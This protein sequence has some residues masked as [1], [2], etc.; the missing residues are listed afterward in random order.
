NVASLPTHD[1]MLAREVPLCSPVALALHIDGDLLIGHQCPGESRDPGRVWRVDRSSR[2]IHRVAGSFD[3]SPE[4]PDGGLA[5]GAS[6]DRP[7]GLATDPS[8]NVYLAEVQAGSPDW[9]QVR[10]VTRA[11]NIV[12]FAGHR[13]AAAGDGSP[14]TNFFLST[15][16]RLLGTASGK[17]LLG[18]TGFAKVRSL[19]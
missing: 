18:E 5:L 3:Q 6:L 9:G 7:T 19:Q 10:V 1:G 16:G 11:G 14:A 15:T 13:R 12:R 8:G 4:P 2:R 17:L